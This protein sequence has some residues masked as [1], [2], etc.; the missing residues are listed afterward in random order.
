MWRTT[1]K[2]GTLFG[3]KLKKIHIDFK[4]VYEVITISQFEFNN[5]EEQTYR[6]KRVHLGRYFSEFVLLGICLEY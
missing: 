2:V 3:R 5:N 1:I 4:S 6:Y